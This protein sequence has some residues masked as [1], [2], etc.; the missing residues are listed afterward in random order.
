VKQLKGYQ[1]EN[2]EQ[3]AELDDCEARKQSLQWNV[4]NQQ[5]KMEKITLQQRVKEDSI[6]CELNDLSK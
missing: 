2:R 1:D 4:V 3:H 5:E 6:K